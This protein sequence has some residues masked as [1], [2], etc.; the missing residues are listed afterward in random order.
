M[1][2]GS[3]FSLMETVHVY[4]NII[5][6]ARRKCAKQTEISYRHK[7]KHFFFRW[8]CLLFT[9]DHIHTN[10]LATTFCDFVVGRF[11][12]H[13]SLGNWERYTSCDVTSVKNWFSFLKLIQ[14]LTILLTTVCNQSWLRTLQTDTVNQFLD[15][16]VGIVFQVKKMLGTWNIRCRKRFRV[17]PKHPVRPDYLYRIQ[18]RCLVCS[19]LPHHGFFLFFFRVN[20]VPAADTYEEC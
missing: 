12:P 8:G 4:S 16:R 1:V 17:S 5:Q 13:K 6:Q 7:T 20:S 11:G 10:A 2:R 19:H 9:C 18:A 15:V 3:V 14:K